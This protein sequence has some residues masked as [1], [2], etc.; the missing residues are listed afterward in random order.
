MNLENVIRCKSK[1]SRTL[2][3]KKIKNLDQNSNIIEGN[4]PTFFL[5]PNFF[6]A[7]ISI[8]LLVFSFT[9]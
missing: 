6:F 7:L 9:P 3:P 5:V 1:I 4:A 2:V 8:N